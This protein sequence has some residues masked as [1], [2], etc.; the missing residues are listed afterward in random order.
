MNLLAD[1]LKNSAPYPFAELNR[2]RDELKANG[3]RIIDMGT[4]DTMLPTPPEVVETLIEKGKLAAHHHYSSYNGVIEF[5]KAVSEWLKAKGIGDFS[6]ESEIT[7]L[8]G[9]KE[10]V[11]RFPQAVINPGEI[12][13]VPEPSYPPYRGGALHAGA[14][15]YSVPLLEENG[16]LPNLDAI[17]E[18]I[19]EKTKLFYLNYPNNP[20]SASMTAEFAEKMVAFAKKYNW[21]VLSD[22]AYCEIYENKRPISLLSF[23]KEKTNVIEFYSFSKGWSMTGWR[24][25]FA[26]GAKELVSGLVKI[27]TA[28]G[29][30]VFEPVQY[31]AIT[32]LKMDETKTNPIRDFYAS[33]RKAVE[34]MLDA[35]GIEYIKADAT[36]Y[37]YVKAPNGFTSESFAT[38]LLEKYYLVTTPASLLGKSGEGF[39]RMALTIDD[40][41]LEILRER[42]KN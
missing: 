7:A 23:D 26:V 1:K 32:A 25:G 15:V 34:A 17:P 29:S 20:T 36:F 28:Q 4:G 39:V 5:R 6:P 8:S 16:F 19:R 35:K 12:A 41:E 40:G 31:A 11:F 42:F 14:E 13:I 24:V 38:Y 3:I 37:L 22:M 10:A 30:S 33:R 18:N 21:A 27:K 9:S 2:K